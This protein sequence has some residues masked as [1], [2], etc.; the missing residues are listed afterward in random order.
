MEKKVL[1]NLSLKTKLKY[2]C[3]S[4]FLLIAP[5][6]MQD[7][8]A[9]TPGSIIKTVHFGKEDLT[10]PM[11]SMMDRIYAIK[12]SGD[13]DKDYVAIM[14]EFQ[15]GGIDLCK[16]YEMSGEDPKLLEHAK[17]GAVELKEDQKL[18]K[19]CCNKNTKTNNRSE[20]ND[21]MKTLAIMMKGIEQKGK[22]GNLNNDYAAVMSYYNWANIEMAKAELRYGLNT[23]LKNRSRGIIEEFSC[24]ENSLAEWQDKSV[25]EK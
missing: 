9:Q 16:I 25:A 18:L 12:M 23:E 13:F 20:P 24:Q 6:M 7:I 2:L 21:L 15:Q 14:Q 22:S 11:N 19:A 4:S 5:V 8:K 17:V 3:V 10:R 1:E